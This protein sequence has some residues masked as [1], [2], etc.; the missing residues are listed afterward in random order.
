[1]YLIFTLKFVGMIQ[2]RKYIVSYVQH[3]FLLAEQKIMLCTYLLISIDQKQMMIEND[4][5]KAT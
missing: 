3:T 1:M 4:P 2:N 5:I